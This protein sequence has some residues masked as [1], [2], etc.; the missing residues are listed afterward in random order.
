MTPKKA[1]REVLSEGGLV[2][3]VDGE[4]VDT[5][6]LSEV[7]TLGAEKSVYLIKGSKNNLDR[8]FQGNL[9]EIKEM[10]ENKAK[11]K[12]ELKGFKKIMFW[13]NPSI[14]VRHFKKD[15]VYWTLYFGDWNEEPLKTVN[16][17][18]Y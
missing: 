17:R 10:V 14:E 12:Y 9:E 1:N 8:I 11:R 15:S 6:I 2:V 4:D 5:M 13:R 16:D 18:K 3:K 7:R